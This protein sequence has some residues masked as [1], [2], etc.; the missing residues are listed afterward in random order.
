MGKRAATK[1][2]TVVAT[3]V[4][5][6]TGRGRSLEAAVLSCWPQQQPR[7][8]LRWLLAAQAV[9]IVVCSNSESEAY[10]LQNGPARTV[11]TAEA[12]DALASS[13]LLAVS[14]RSSPP[15]APQPSLKRA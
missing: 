10:T 8:R 15:S 5:T 13:L 6:T 7:R 2:A 4:G 9:E 3:V 14:S 11:A 12:E 1:A